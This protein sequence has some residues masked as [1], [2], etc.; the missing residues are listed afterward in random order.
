MRSLRR[1]QLKYSDREF[2]SLLKE[3]KLSV[4]Q[5][6]SLNSKIFRGNSEY[7]TVSFNPVNRETLARSIE[8][9]SFSGKNFNVEFADFIRNT[10]SAVE[11]FYEKSEAN[12]KL[13]LSLPDDTEIRETLSKKS[14]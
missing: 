6:D 9:Q 13:F 12:L 10:A 5:I 8:G 7:F 2:L 4:T 3:L 11:R 1:V 14:Q